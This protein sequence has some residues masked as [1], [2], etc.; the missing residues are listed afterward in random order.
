MHE[1]MNGETRVIFIV[2]DP[3]THVKSPAGVTELFSRRQHNAIVVPAHVDPDNL[4]PWMNGI[5]RAKNV[6]GIIIAVPHKFACFELCRSTSTRSNFL[7]SV[8]A[9]RRNPDGSWHGDVLDGDAFVQTLQSK[10]HALQNKRALLVGCGA[11]GTAVGYALIKAGI[12]ELGIHDVDTPQR[13][14]LVHRLSS[15]H[16]GSVRAASRNPTGFD[17]IVDA[18]PVTTQTD[19]SVPVDTARLHAGMVVCCTKSPP[20]ITP[21]IEAA[22]HHGC[23]TITGTEIFQSAR[24]LLVEFLLDTSPPDEYASRPA[25]LAPVA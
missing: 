20:E 23:A 11:M 17:L 15:L 7:S 22:Q 2:G 16:Y 12:A 5:S 4:T 21:L 3:I 24:E 18:T 10:G 1:L 14:A 19:A 9:M 6:D 8:N 13:D 25:R